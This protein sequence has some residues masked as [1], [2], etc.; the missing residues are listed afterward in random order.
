MCIRDLE[1]L[2]LILWFDFKLE[3]ILT[4]TSR[5]VIGLKKVKSD[6]INHLA[7]FT[8]VQSKSLVHTVEVNQLVLLI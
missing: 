8:N 6:P 5:I 4:T 2:N 1:K 3:P 7:Y